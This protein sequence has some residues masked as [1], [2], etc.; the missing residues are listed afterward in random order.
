M[1]GWQAKAL[2]EKRPDAAFTAL[3]AL[4]RLGGADTQP[5]IVKALTAFPPAKLSEEQL[6]DKLRVYE[7]SI[8]RQGIPSG[9]TL[10]LLIAD[11]D[12]LYPAKTE[13]LNRELCQ[14][15]VAVY[16]PNAVARSV[17]LMKAAPNQEEQLTYIVDLRNVKTGWTADLRRT[18]LSW[19]DD[20]RSNQH[21]PGVVQWFTDA[22]IGF[23][24]GSSFKNLLS[25]AL[26]DA[27]ASMSPEE[28]A[29]LGNPKQPP[30]AAKAPAAERKF[31][32]E[33]TTADLQP[34]L[35]QVSKGRDFARGKAGFE[36]GQCILCHRYQ[37]Q[38]G[39]VGPDLTAVAT[40]FKR[41]DI[42]ESITEP[43]KVLSEQ[44]MNTIFTLKDGN[45]MV[46]RVIQE[47]ETTVQIAQNPF[48]PLTTPIA[49]ADIKSRDLSKVSPMPTGLLNTFTREEILDLL[50]FLESMGDPKHPNFGK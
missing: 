22:G 3:L 13:F 32:K 12:P 7:V 1:E 45:V 43:S 25:H 23:N 10:Q 44:Y 16:A 20:G 41:Q 17:A 28:V 37:D 49:K 31:V 50:A 33:W 9:E 34:L 27:K 4:V 21:P 38:G 14:I 6:L 48:V 39:S 40:R 35:D 18:Y 24:N 42:L 30:P 29:A 11:V 19:W 36:A 46:G 2:S 26:K 8:A 15:L 47:N 5:M